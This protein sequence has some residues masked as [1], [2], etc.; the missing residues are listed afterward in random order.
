MAR[1]Q[2]LVVRNL[3]PFLHV[4]AALPPATRREVRNELR[5]VA[6]TVRDDG[7]RKFSRYSQRSA[8]GYRVVV[9]RRGISVEQSL[10]KTTGNNPDWGK[11][12]MREALIPALDDNTEKLVR[13]LERAID[14]IANRIERG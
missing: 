11:L 4:V 2:G 10:R 6:E 5:Q 13:D 14:R 8:D 7:E 12:Q 3:T 9:R 1:V